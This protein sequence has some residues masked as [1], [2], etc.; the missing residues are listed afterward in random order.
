MCNSVTFFLCWFLSVINLHNRN[1]NILA[2]KIRAFRNFDSFVTWDGLRVT[3]WQVCLVQC[4]LDVNLIYY[5]RVFELCASSSTV[6]RG[7][8]GNWDLFTS[9][10]YMFISV[11]KHYF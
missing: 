9:S 5:Y 7:H 1:R 2:S 8:L 10:L 6:N 11:R 3:D 4:A